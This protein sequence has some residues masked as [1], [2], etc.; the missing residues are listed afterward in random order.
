MEKL[1]IKYA[2]LHGMYYADYYIAKGG[3]VVFVC[4]DK[5]K[6]E[7]WFIVLQWNPFKCQTWY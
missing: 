7:R 4:Y 2:T 6:K 5:N 3:H 1:M